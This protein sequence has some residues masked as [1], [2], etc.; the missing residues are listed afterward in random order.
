MKLLITFIHSAG[1]RIQS[2]RE[3]G[4]APGPRSDFLEI[5]GFI[6]FI[7]TCFRNVIAKQPLMNSLPPFFRLAEKERVWILAWIYKTKITQVDTNCINALQQC[8]SEI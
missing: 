2:S 1:A 8:A 6:Y 3:A 4:F 7:I 5:L